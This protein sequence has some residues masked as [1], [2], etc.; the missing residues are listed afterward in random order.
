MLTGLENALKLKNVSRAARK[1]HDVLAHAQRTRTHPRTH[2]P[3]DVYESAMMP[4]CTRSCRS[5]RTRIDYYTAALM[6]LGRLQAGSCLGRDES[7]RRAGTP[8][9]DACDNLDSGDSQIPVADVSSHTVVRRREM[10][11][12]SMHN[13]HCAYHTKVG[14]NRSCFT[15]PGPRDTRSPL[16]LGVLMAFLLLV[17]CASI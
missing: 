5:A 13:T 1:T 7:G 10:T 4:Y 12:R 6:L 14:A 9:G 3:G 16:F 15:F 11:I 17:P 8:G 2:A